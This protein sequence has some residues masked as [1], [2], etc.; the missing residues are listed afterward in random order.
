M[1][2]LQKR[3]MA[4]L[5]VLLTLSV[6]LATSALAGDRETCE[7][8]KADPSVAVAACTR[9]IGTLRDKK[10]LAYTYMLRANR[11]E[12]KGDHEAAI[13]D[14]GTGIEINPNN[15]GYMSRGAHYHRMKEYDRALTDFT[16]ALTKPTTDP[17][18][19]RTVI[20]FLRA[21]TY[22][23]LGRISDAIVDYRAAHAADIPGAAD[24]LKRLGVT[25]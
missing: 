12:H 3:L 17:F 18:M 4:G 14:R 9:L 10:E 25:P 20:Y 1:G 7:D 8:R 24:A 11:Y 15:T 22:E 5:T 2:E 21:K 16:T 19:D 23:A 13:R 6:V